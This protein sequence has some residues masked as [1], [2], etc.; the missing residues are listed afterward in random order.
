MSSAFNKANRCLPSAVPE[1][2]RAELARQWDDQVYQWTASL[3]FRYGLSPA[4]VGAAALEALARPGQGAQLARSALAEERA[5]LERAY[6][7]G[8]SPEG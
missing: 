7:V 3:G 8:P 5:L 2:E 4:Q 1:G 6:P